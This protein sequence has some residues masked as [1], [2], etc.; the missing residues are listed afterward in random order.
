[1]TAES[2]RHP[3]LSLD[4]IA[5]GFFTRKGGV[6]EGVYAAL[7]CGLGSGDEREK[8]LENRARVATALG[9]EAPNLCTVYQVHSPE[10]VILTEPFSGTPPQ[11]DGM[12]TNVPELAI[13][14]L[15]ADCAPILFA[16]PQARVVGCAHAGWRGALAGVAEATVAAMERLG[17]HRSVIRAVVGPCISSA[18]YEIG[19][20]FAAAFMDA[21]PENARFFKAAERPGHAYFDLPGFA[22]DRLGALGLHTVA[23]TDDCT[24]ADEDRFFSYRRKTH[25]NEPDY[26]RQIS[27]IALS[28]MDG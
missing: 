14:A 26:G 1:M 12:V 21:A 10:V 24:Y 19:P 28:N 18:N 11:A 13:G 6:S 22:V 9:V 20:D 25:R 16:E 3:A 8:V 23:A 7:N 27:A 4:G 2:I 17:A 5:H 15:A